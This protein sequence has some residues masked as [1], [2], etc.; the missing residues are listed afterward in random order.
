MLL[1]WKKY[2]YL[3]LGKITTRIVRAQLAG[4]QSS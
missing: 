4:T 3:I 1:F 2:L